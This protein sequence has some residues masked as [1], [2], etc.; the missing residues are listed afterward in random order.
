MLES[1]GEEGGGMPL[2]IEEVE[3]GDS[4]KFVQVSH[5]MMM[6]IRPVIGIHEG[7]LVIGSSESSITKCFE[8]AQGERKS[9]A[10]SERFEKEGLVP[11]GPFTFLSWTDMSSFGDQMAQA[12]AMMGFA[13]AMIPDKPGAAAVRGVFELMSDLAPVFQ[14]IDFILSTATVSTFEGDLMHSKTVY[15]YKPP[16]PEEEEEEVEE[17]G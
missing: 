4:D 14:E 16:E 2:S 5:P 13:G 1:L 6:M 17:E 15:N 12:F 9:I 7:W 10:K 11:D 8:T 3:I